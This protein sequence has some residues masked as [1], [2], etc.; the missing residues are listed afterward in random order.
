LIE[1]RLNDSC[2]FT[3]IKKI[4]LFI[5]PFQAILAYIHVIPFLFSEERGAVVA[6]LTITVQGFFA[7]VSTVSMI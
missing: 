2:L 4:I 7:Y 1:I 3:V 6:V 5:F